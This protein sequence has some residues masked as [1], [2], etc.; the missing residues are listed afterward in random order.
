MNKPKPQHVEMNQFG[1][2]DNEL[3]IGG[4]KITELAQQLGQTPFY[5][6]DKKVIEGTMK[7]LREIL[8]DEISIHYAIKA[9][10]MPELVHYMA[11]LTD[12]FDLASKGEL[13]TALETNKPAEHISI[14]GPGKT[15]NE[16]KAAIQAGITINMES[17]GEMRRIQAISDSLGVTANVAIRVNPD[18]NIKASGMKMVGG[19]RQ[20]GIDE[21]LVPGILETLKSSKLQFVGFHIY[22]GSQFL[23]ETAIIETNSKI[24][25]LAIRL[26]NAAHISPK[27]L[28]IGGGFGIPYFPGDKRLSLN[29]IASELKIQSQKFRSQ[30]PET[31]IYM[32]LGRYLV[33]E[34][35]VY[36]TRVIDKKISRGTTYLITDGG[37]HH[38]LAASGNF[39]QIIRKNYP[40]CIATNMNEDK[41]ELVSIVG[42]L[43]TPLDI[44]ADKMMLPVANEGDLVCIYQSGAYGLSASPQGF[45][46]RQN[47][48]EIL[49]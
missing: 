49:I 37:M 19:P 7:N 28:N 38:H 3:V 16:L 31:K 40:V 1:I 26:S 25:D 32:E 24:F 14:A 27:T 8:P 47:A 30:Y 20:F 10:P 23:N 4:V 43:C 42:P 12:G 33:G 41:K 11:T 39:G 35:G 44:L 2:R 17:A 46:S 9:N 21:E 6:Y 5:A 34:A 15:D 29:N 36:I 22:S 18:F 48:L 13:L 45:L